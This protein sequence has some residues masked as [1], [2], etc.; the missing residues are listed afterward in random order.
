MTQL[1][2][3]DLTPMYEGDEGNRIALAAELDAACREIGFFAVV[4]TRIEPELV[5]STRASVRSFFELPLE[6]KLEVKP[7]TS[8]GRGYVPV[9]GEALSYTTSFAAPPDLKESFSIG[10]IE[11]GSDPYFRYEPSGIAFAPNIWPQQPASFEAD[12]RHYYEAL[13][14]LA[15]D[16]MALTARSFSLP[17]DWFAAKADRPT[18][19]LR[20]LHYPPRPVL[21]DRQF[22]ASPH[23]DY[24]TWTILKKRPGL[25]GLQ[26]QAVSG[27][28]VD[29]VA[30]ADGFVVN[31]GDLLMRWTGGSW[32]ST[33]HRVVPVDEV[34][35]GGEI[36][37][38][39][40][41]QPNWDV[42]VYPFTDDVVHRP[43]VDGRYA[44]DSA[45]RHF[46][47]VTVGEFVFGKYKATVSDEAL[48]TPGTA[49]A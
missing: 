34:E 11:V 36:S 1:R 18:S 38:V 13:A 42:V 29:V 28:W 9:E 39:F 48:S 14:G 35:E 43:E 40:F 12:L 6:A 49:S 7:A 30:P 21:G 33:L 32:L 25:T 23:T 3:I 46:Y 5:S 31:V 26:A 17:P 45:E 16:L 47:G 27:E 10:P 4:G 15:D 2:T 37:L 41:H 20:V 24:G 19:A 44:A 8:N 22:P